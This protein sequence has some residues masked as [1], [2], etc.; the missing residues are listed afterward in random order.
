MA[1]R[2]FKERIAA[3]VIGFIM[4]FSVAGFAFMNVGRFSSDTAPA[5]VPYIINR[6]LTQDERR[7]VL[8][9][10]RVLIQDF[11]PSNCTECV[12]IDVTLQEFATRFQKFVVLEMAEKNDTKMQMIGRDGKIVDLL[13]TNLTAE[14][15]L[16]VFCDLAVAQP[17]ECLLESE[18]G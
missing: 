1:S 15:M 10:G 13:E 6:E 18:F 14:E 17:M 11:H 8:L 9:T 16:P 5:E 7:T 2:L 3:I 12:E 4:I